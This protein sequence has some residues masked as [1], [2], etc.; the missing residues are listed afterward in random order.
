[1]LFLTLKC[2][3]EYVNSK[4]D[5]GHARMVIFKLRSILK[6][7]SNLFHLVYPTS[8]LICEKELPS[9]K[10]FIC[11]FCNNELKYTYFERYIEPT[12]LDQLFWGRIPMVAT[13]SYIYFEKGKSTQPILH[14]LKY[15]DKPELGVEMGKLIG[16]QVKKIASFQDVDALVPVPIHPKKEFTR[17]YNQ[18]EKLA[19]G[20]AEILNTPVLISYI[21]KTKDSDSQTKKGRFKRWDNVEDKFKTN[22]KTEFKHIAI[23]DDV[24][25]T[26][27]TLEAII[28]KIQ[29]NNPE[30]RVSIISLALTK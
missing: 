19:D 30:I 15:G 27:A 13:Y 11:S 10:K 6:W 23:V 9:D 3:Y 4:D 18:S 17:G 14:A 28:R 5:N 21:E 20:I 1:M 16:E 22:S 2:V 7:S 24:I 12:P 26:G 29:E 8:C 25:T